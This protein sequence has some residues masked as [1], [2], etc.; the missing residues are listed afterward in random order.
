MTMLPASAIILAGGQSRRMGKPKAALMF[1]NRTILERLLGELRGCF[2]DVLVIAAPEQSEPFP[3]E[4]LLGAAAPSV[5]LLRDL[6]AYQGAAQAL[7]RGIAAAAHD[8]AF[9]C[10]CDLPLLR[11]EVARALHG[12]LNGYD[13]VIP[14]LDAKP[15]PLCAVYRRSVAA[16]IEKQLAAG[17]R[18]LTR[19]TA[20]I[21][22]YRPGDRQLREI[23][24][25]LHSF[26]NVNAPED[27]KRALAI[28]QSL[29]PGS[30]GA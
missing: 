9:A 5:R 24:P 6:A 20:Q 1:G 30:A 12:M 10:S 3:I 14:N 18:R 23:D 27:F 28:L 4:H 16:W 13:G 22:A 7:A 25:D 21:R 8:V 11:A 19:I 2:D 29:E 26:I 17:E 15:Q